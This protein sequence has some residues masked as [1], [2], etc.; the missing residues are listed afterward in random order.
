MLVSASVC[1]CASH[2]CVEGGHGEDAQASQRG[3]A[4][5]AGRGQQALGVGQLA[6][7]QAGQVAAHAEKVHVETLQ[8]LLPLLDLKGGRKHRVG[9]RQGD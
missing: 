6:A 4:G 8:V 3:L 5:P 2:Q 7:L 9:E 1:V